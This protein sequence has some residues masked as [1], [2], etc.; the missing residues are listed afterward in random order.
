MAFLQKAID[1]LCKSVYIG[2]SS[3][4]LW[5]CIIPVYTCILYNYYIHV[6]LYV[7]AFTTG[8]VVK[9]KPT[10]VVAG[11]D[12]ERTNEFLQVL[13]ISILK[14]VRPL[15]DIP[16]ILSTSQ[17]PQECIVHDAIVHAR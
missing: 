14:Q 15:I 10:K 6:H 8:E 16:R 17:F 12:A 13:S 5:F 1:T 2:I 9:L 4:I 3:L 11:H 7:A